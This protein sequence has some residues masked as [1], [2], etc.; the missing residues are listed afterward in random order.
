MDNISIQSFPDPDGVDMKKYVW[1]TIVGLILLAGWGYL[2][3]MT[4]V[5]EAERVQK[6]P[7][8]SPVHAT[9][10]SSS[11]T[12]IANGLI[13]EPIYANNKLPKEVEVKRLFALYQKK[14]IGSGA[15]GRELL[16]AIRALGLPP[17]VENFNQVQ[18]LIKSKTTTEERVGLTRILA[19]FF[20]INNAL[21]FNDGV[22]ADLKEL[23]NSGNKDVAGTAA[24]EYTYFGYLPDSQHVLSYAKEAGYITDEIYY[25]QLSRVADSAPKDA[26][27]EILNK[28]KLGGNAYS[29]E[30][31]TSDIQT[32]ENL[33]KYSPETYT[34]LK[35]ILAEHQP[36]FSE[37]PS[38]FGLT[39]AVTY[40]AWLQAVA[41]V[42]SN[43]DPGSSDQFLLNQLNNNKTDPR[44]II[45]FLITGEGDPLIQ[46][47]GPSGGLARAQS[48]M[49]LYAAQTALNLTAQGAID[50][51]KTKLRTGGVR[52]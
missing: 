5:E 30:I 17:T 15:K 41:L 42:N 39:K 32:P 2:H 8:L 1:A 7:P 47:Y 16:D 24:L 46:R 44:K 26:Q 9:S 37:D 19:N 20:S 11:P 14:Y 50:E 45:S 18:E 31:L 49:E 27:Q 51:I 40:S 34:T 22:I 21:G 48:N 38:Q 25:A 35:T 43:G 6:N 3:I 52:R 12:E 28:I 13:S 4:L 36:E 33:K 29:I 10:P 23:V